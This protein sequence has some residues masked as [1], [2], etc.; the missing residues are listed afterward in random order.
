M[1][2]EMFWSCV[3]AILFL[4]CLRVAFLMCL[5]ALETYLKGKAGIQ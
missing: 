5:G 2:V 4:G 3:G 1:N